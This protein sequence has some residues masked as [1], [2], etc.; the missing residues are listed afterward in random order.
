MRKLISRQSMYAWMLIFIIGINAALFVYDFLSPE[1]RMA[2]KT[3]EAK[4]ILELKEM[5]QLLISKLSSDKWMEEIW[6][7]KTF[8][9]AVAAGLFFTVVNL[10]IV[11]GF[12]LSIIF[13]ISSLRRK[14]VVKPIRKP[15]KVNWDIR[16]IF[17][18]GILLFFYSYLINILEIILTRMG[19]LPVE[20]SEGIMMIFNTSI[21]HVLTVGFIFYFIVIKYKQNLSSL[22]LSLKNYF[23]GI[24]FG[25]A[26]YLVILP[27]LG[28]VFILS[29]LIAK[30]LGYQPPSSPLFRIFFKEK[31]LILVG[32]SVFLAVLAGPIVEEIFFRG[33]IYS[34]VKKKIGVWRAIVL[35]AILFSLIH[36]NLFGFI[37]ILI[38]GIALAWLYEK[39]GSLIPSITLHIVHNSLIM[40][41]ML[42]T[43]ALVIS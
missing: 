35:T 39:T 21:L 9:L 37:P 16:D 4:E 29:T 33:F 14:E 7:E 41:F 3:D 13:V 2:K 31:N 30:H 38:L 28:L 24:R 23:K 5:E 1:N 15:E 10:A 18:I 34:A 8:L 19:L 22:G 32:Y 43:R 36:R 17:K 26:G 11:A 6:K 40:S 27:V 12:V 25:A 20:L 42:L